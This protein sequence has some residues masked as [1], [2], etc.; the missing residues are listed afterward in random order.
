MGGKIEN[1]DAFIDTVMKTELTG[2]PLGKTV[3]AR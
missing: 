1:R 3:Q 2:S